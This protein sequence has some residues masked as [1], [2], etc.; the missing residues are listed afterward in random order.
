MIVFV[1]SIFKSNAD[2]AGDN[3]PAAGHAK[4]SKEAAAL[5]AVF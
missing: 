5:P 1:F 3:K 2:R 4:D